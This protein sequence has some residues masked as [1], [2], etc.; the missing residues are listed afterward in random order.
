MSDATGVVEGVVMLH[1][2]LKKVELALTLKSAK[3]EKTHWLVQ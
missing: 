1:Y 3:Y 2:S